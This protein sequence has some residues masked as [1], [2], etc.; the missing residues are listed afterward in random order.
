M[1]LRVAGRRPVLLL[2]TGALTAGL[3][4]ACSFGSG[5]PSGLSG[6]VL[7]QQGEPEEGVDAQDERAVVAR[8]IG[9]LDGRERAIL[10][11]RFGVEGEGLSL[12]EIGRRLGLTRE[13]VRQLEGRA[14]SKLRRGHPQGGHD[15][16]SSAGRDGFGEPESRRTVA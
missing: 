3:L 1:R 10:M 13:W 4:A 6:A 2:T 11:L 14:L 9:R 16:R 7:D 15:L 12:A 5:L 8:R